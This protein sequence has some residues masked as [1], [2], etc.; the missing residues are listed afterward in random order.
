MPA[1]MSGMWWLAGVAGTIV[2]FVIGGAAYWRYHSHQRTYARSRDRE[3]KAHEARM[4]TRD[5]KDA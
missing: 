5:D 3:R 2:A 1:M 4:A